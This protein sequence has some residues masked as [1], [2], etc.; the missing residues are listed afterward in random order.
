MYTEKGENIKL[1]IDYMGFM[2]L[3]N[4]LSDQKLKQKIKIEDKNRR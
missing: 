2:G 4:L 1:G 3:T